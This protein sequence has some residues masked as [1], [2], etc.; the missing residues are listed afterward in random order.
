MTLIL[1]DCDFLQKVEIDTVCSK[2][3][4]LVFNAIFYTVSIQNFLDQEYIK[5]T[6]FFSK[7]F[8]I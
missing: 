7:V 6:I 2:V 3:T 4:M 5:C 1:C 8:E